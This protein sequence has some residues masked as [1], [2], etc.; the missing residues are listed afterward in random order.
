MKKT[1][2]VAMSIFLV[3]FVFASCTNDSGNPGF[4]G[5]AEAVANVLKPADLVND[6]LKPNT[7]GVDV[8]YRIINEAT[9]STAGATL[10][11]T[12]EFSGYAVPDSSYVITSGKLIYKFSGNV[13]DGIFTAGTAGEVTTERSL[14]IKTDAGNVDVAI[15]DKSA[16][17]N[18][19]TADVSKAGSEDG[20]LPSG[21]S[22]SVSITIAKSGTVEIGGSPV[23]IPGTSNPGGGSGESEKT[24]VINDEASLLKY[25]DGDY[26][27][28]TA[29]IPAG[30]SIKLASAVD[31][32]KAGKTIRGGN[33]AG[34][35]LDPSKVID[36]QAL[37][38]I[39]S[40]DITIEGVKFS[41][42]DG[43]SGVDGYNI[44]KISGTESSPVSNVKLRDVTFD[45]GTSKAAGLNIHFSSACL[46]DNVT[47][48]GTPSKDSLAIAES[49]SLTVRD[50]AF[51]PGSWGYAVQ[52]N[53]DNN[54]S[55]AEGVDVTFDGGSIPSVYATEG[56][57]NGGTIKHTV[58]GLDSF[59]RFESVKAFTG[60]GDYKET[61][62]LYLPKTSPTAEIIAYAA[63]IGS[64][65][66]F[67]RID[68]ALKD[69][70]LTYSNKDGSI[71]TIADNP[72]IKGDAVTIGVWLTN[73][74][75]S[76]KNSHRVSGY[77]DFTFKGTSGADNV[78][79]A[80]SWSIKSSYLL[81][82]NQH[83]VLLDVNGGFFNG[84]AKLDVP[85]NTA[86]KGILNA[87][88]NAEEG[89]ALK[90]TADGLSG[91]SSLDGK[92]YDFSLAVK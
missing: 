59:A 32:T 3:L 82:D 37:F 42:A 68:N 21:F 65:R 71:V 66:I 16:A 43:G 62:T 80:S 19:F 75:Y 60:V 92:A 9:R 49:K 7:K 52:I 17:I 41:I 10:K 22:V 14:S 13:S 11:A 90:F 4:S 84:P 8:E 85:D 83:V 47:V 30:T 33:G 89:Q 29:V 54:D 53:W 35:I 73:F 64:D 88:Q 38:R 57:A 6:V 44:L 15:N 70:D 91:I 31:I 23:E 48:T 18:T 79:S 12:V 56:V 81:I 20:I 58:K 26:A 69:P 25:L 72:V 55:Y 61:G 87:A 28:T 39:S 74:P 45:V 86:V 46:L 78:F 34:I 77:F 76:T 67:N 63:G 51:V 40:S 1:L 5:N 27:D 36:H 24:I 50:C 2:Y